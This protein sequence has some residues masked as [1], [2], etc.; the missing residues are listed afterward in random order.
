MR[1]EHLLGRIDEDK[2]FLEQEL[3]Q[4]IKKAQAFDAIA[5]KTDVGTYVQQLVKTYEQI[6]DRKSLLKKKME[7]LAKIV[8]GK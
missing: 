4:L 5:K 2:H 7:Q 8:R 1:T 3:R 6:E